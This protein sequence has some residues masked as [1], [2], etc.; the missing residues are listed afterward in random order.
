MFVVALS[1]VD[2]GRLS[3]SEKAD[4]EA[5][6][7]KVRHELPMSSLV[8]KPQRIERRQKN[9]APGVVCVDVRCERCMVALSLPTTYRFAHRLS[10]ALPRPAVVDSYC[11]M[12]LV[13]A[14]P[15]IRIR[16]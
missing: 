4:R 15:S 8:V 5:F 3:F 11:R 7:E 2:E 1:E 10:T 12:L 9:K 16:M 6:A 13:N 14:D